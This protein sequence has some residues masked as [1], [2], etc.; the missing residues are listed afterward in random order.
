MRER[1]FRVKLKKELRGLFPGCLIIPGDSGEIQGLPDLIIL[2]KTRWAAL[3]TKKTS[4]SN[5]RLNQ[6][7]YVDLMNEMSFAA[8]VCPENKEEVLYE[9]QQALTSRRSARVSRSK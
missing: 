2:Y 5:K 3:E 1:R 7:Y 6:D 9:L 8:F 4:T